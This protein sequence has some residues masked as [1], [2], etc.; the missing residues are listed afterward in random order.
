MK[1]CTQT[2]G[3]IS[4]QMLG[5]TVVVC[6]HIQIRFDCNIKTSSNSAL[7]GEDIK[8]VL[9]N[10]LCLQLFKELRDVHRL[11]GITGHFLRGLTVTKPCFKKK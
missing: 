4:A 1:S 7:L 5:D 11:L 3:Q 9:C 8:E 6:L 10:V 2:Q